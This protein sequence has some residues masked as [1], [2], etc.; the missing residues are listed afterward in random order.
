MKM[1]ISHVNAQRDSTAEKVHH[2]ADKMMCSGDN[3]QPLSQPP[4]GLLGGPMNQGAMVARMQALQGSG[5]M[6]FP[7]Q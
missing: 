6:N 5:A 1:F 7:S 4:Q 2:Q 3:S